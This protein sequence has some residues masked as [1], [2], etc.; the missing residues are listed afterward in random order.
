MAAPI[1]RR[2][3]SLQAGCV[4]L[5]AVG[6]YTYTP[7]GSAVP[8]PDDQLSLV[9]TDQGR[10]DAGGALGPSLERVDGRLVRMSDSIYLLRV[11]RVTDLGGVQTPWRGGTLS[12][13]PAGGGATH[14]RP[15]SPSPPP[16]PPRL[17]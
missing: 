6:C 17:S 2:Q 7:V 11:L 15:L 8:V 13:P 12:G 1:K 14:Q 10:V 5:L 16:P 9:F 3:W 4:A